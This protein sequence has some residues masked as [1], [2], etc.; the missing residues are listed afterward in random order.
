MEQD[1]SL[2]SISL[3]FPELEEEDEDNLSALLLSPYD[4]VDDDIELLKQLG[5][6][7]PWLNVLPRCYE[8]AK[9]PQNK[10]DEQAKE[11]VDALH[12]TLETIRDKMKRNIDITNEQKSITGLSSFFRVFD[13]IINK[14]PIKGSDVIQPIKPP[15]MKPIPFV[16][17]NDVV[18]NFSASK[19][20]MTDA[21]DFSQSFVFDREDGDDL[22]QTF[23]DYAQQANKPKKHGKFIDGDKVEFNQ[24]IFKPGN[25]FAQKISDDEINALIKNAK[26]A[27]VRGKRED[28]DA[29]TVLENIDRDF[30]NLNIQSPA[31]SS[32]YYK[33]NFLDLI[34]NGNYRIKYIPAASTR[35]QATIYCHTHLDQDGKP[36]YRLL[37]T[38]AMD[39]NGEAITDLNGDKIDD[40]VLVDKKGVPQ[41]INGYKLVFASPYKK[42]WKTVVKSAE[43]RKAK[44]FNVWLNEQF[45]KSKDSVDWEKGEYIIN[46][47][48]TIQK[49]TEFYHNE[50]GLG[51]PKVSKRLSPSSYW[52]SYFAKVWKVF[53]QLFPQFKP[54][55]RIISYLSVSNV[56]FCIYFDNNVKK[57]IEKGGQPMNYIQ[58]LAWKKINKSNYCQTKFNIYFLFQPK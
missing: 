49:Y 10:L 15:S 36:K 37:P 1:D 34:I 23:T 22:N 53:W 31:K 16:K 7:Q 46:P 8:A 11:N 56:L 30:T 24:K 57:E 55:T 14:K 9:K 27:T 18:N 33:Q 20:V 35:D 4:L 43:E 51:K 21:D 25:P 38:N 40:I 58:W 52:S 2:P 54:L 47:N 13:T 29:P 6:N 42:V 44:P 45:N 3:N 19:R 32:T 26:A 28:R 41:I 50:L 17:P 48:E 5:Y 39:P 12:Q